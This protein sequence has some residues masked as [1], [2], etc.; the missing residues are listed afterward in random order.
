MITACGSISASRVGSDLNPAMLFFRLAAAVAFTIGWANPL[1]AA[2]PLPP[3]LELP[4]TGVDPN[5]IDFATLPALRGKH[6]LVT[7]PDATWG[8]RLHSYLAY[9]GGRYWCM[10]SHG[11]AREDLPLQH[12]RYATSMDGLNWSEAREIVGP[13]SQQDWRYIARG[14]WLRGGQLVALAS[15]DEVYDAQGKKRLFGPGLELRAWKWNDAT[16][17]WGDA[18]VV[19]RDAINNF[20]PRRVPGR[21]EWLMILRNHRRDVYGLVGGV[22][23]ISDWSRIVLGNAQRAAGF[24]PEEPEWWPLADGR[25]LGV[26]R[27]NGGS[28]RLF[29]AVSS[30]AGRTWSAPEKTNFPDATAKFFALRTSRG[31]HVLVSN[32]NPTKPAQR[33]PLCA[34]TSDDGI[35]FTRLAA[36]PIPAQPEDRPLDAAGKRILGRGYQYPHV[37]EQDGALLIAFSRNKESIEV[38]RVSLDEFQR[39]RAKPLPR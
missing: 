32:A 5:R 17:T 15:H 33:I 27:D 20:P 9:H 26:Y 2:E 25:L 29:R 30:D 23:S 38:V 21:E 7:L 22:T 6:A 35:T 4:E 19:A 11:T 12:V 37:I 1:A 31:F 34:A 3:M 16:Q 18:G 13:S 14:F 28:M 10:W 39:L 36:L 24:S 8:F